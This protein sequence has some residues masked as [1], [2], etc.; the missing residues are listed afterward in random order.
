MKTRAYLD[1]NATAPLRPA[2]KEA[3][4]RAFDCAG[5]ASSIHADGRAAR[6]I[7]ERAREDIAQACGTIST[8][9]TFASGATEANNAVLRT[10]QGERILVSAIEHPSVLETAP[11]AEKIPVTQDGV[12]DIQAFETML[13]GGPVPTLVSIMLVNNETGAIQPVGELARLA[14]SIHPKIFIHTDAAQALGRIPLDFGSYQ[15][16]YMSLSAHKIGGPQGVGALIVAPGAR[17]ARLLTGGGQEKRQR[18]GTENVAGI[19]GFGAAAADAVAKL[20]DFAQLADLRD[21]M[22]RDIRAIEPRV[23]IAGGNAPRV[24]N[25]SCIALPGIPAETQL[26][27]LDLAGIA[28]SSGSACSSGTV[29]ISHVLQAMKLPASVAGGALRI[30]TGWATTPFD[31]DRFVEAWRAMHARL[32]DRVTAP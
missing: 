5:N 13:R 9:I 20:D 19:A 2:A 32:K 22:E 14:R 8:Q 7:V 3:M 26:M 12:I 11:D 25:T 31:V 21:R 30:S 1:Y 6:S 28:V 24:A 18:A 27:A 10:F 29:K 23:V 16:D 15:A 17:P 4:L